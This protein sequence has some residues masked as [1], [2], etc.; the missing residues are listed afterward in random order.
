MESARS[1]LFYHISIPQLDTHRINTHGSRVQRSMT[2]VRQWLSR[3]LCQPCW[4]TPEDGNVM[5]IIPVIYPTIRRQQCA[6]SHRTP[7]SPLLLLLLAFRFSIETTTLFASHSAL[8]FKTAAR[9]YKTSVLHRQPR[10]MRA[11]AQLVFYT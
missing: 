10:T 2:Q 9:R 1:C 6:V 3:P 8:S 11:Q 5:T 7:L 4:S